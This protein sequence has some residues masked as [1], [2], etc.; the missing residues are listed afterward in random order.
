MKKEKITAQKALVHRNGIDESKVYC[1]PSESTD[2]GAIGKATEAI[3]SAL[4]A[5][6]GFTVNPVSGQGKQD[7]IVYRKDSNGKKHRVNIEVKTG[8]G[9]ITE[10]LK[11]SNFIIY[12]VR[13]QKTTTV[14]EYAEQFYMLRT[15]DFLDI[16]ETLGLIQA[17][18]ST[19]GKIVQAIQNFHQKDKKTGEKVLSKK[20]RQFVELLTAYNIDNINNFRK[21]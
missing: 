18:V 3:F 17:K 14:K 2:S 13:P 5:A 11:K 21:V 15:A 12:A 16:L 19:R 8:R 1:D 6:K 7:I 4:L 10:T 9:E 20:G